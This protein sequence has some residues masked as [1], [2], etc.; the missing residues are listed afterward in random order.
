[1]SA[2][3]QK[4]DEEVVD[5]QLY[6][7]KGLRPLRGPKPE[8]M[9][10]G[11]YF[12]CIGAAQTF[13][14]YCQEP[15]PALLGKKLNLPH[16]NFG[17]AGAGPSF[18]T[19]REPIVQYV[20]DG[21]FAIVQI[22]S[23]R[24]VSNHLF[25]SE[26]VELLE[27]RTDGVSQ[28]AKL[29]YDELIAAGDY[30]T[31]NRVIHETRMN[32]VDD[33]INLLESIRVPKILLWISVR[34]PSYQSKFNNGANFLGQYPQLVNQEMVDLIKPFA[35]HYVE[36]VSDAGLPQALFNKNTGK[37]VTVSRRFDNDD[38]AY[39]AYYPSPQMQAEA[40]KALIPV[41]KLLKS[42]AGIKAGLAT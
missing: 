21:A 20:N 26:G 5:Y 30:R 15:Y 9:P 24:S 31:I 27:R 41:C 12:C 35:E 3:Y 6:R 36:S 22:M 33:Y 7:F 11:G 17:I 2:G 19:R 16:R 39:N 38:R 25:K 8:E 4:R 29:M 40:S 18:F 14:R 34:K 37:P 10:K 1:M 32:W 42:T 13:G 28:G 23:A